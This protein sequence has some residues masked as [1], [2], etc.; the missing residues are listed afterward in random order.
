MADH[1]DSSSY[2]QQQEGANTP[3]AAVPASP[4]GQQSVVL[5]R[6]GHGDSMGE[7]GRAGAEFDEDPLVVAAWP[8][9][10]LLRV[11]YDQNRCVLWLLTYQS[12]LVYRSISRQ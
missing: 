9:G 11:L 12:S 8:G 2:Q 6:G 7:R 3:T 5:P 1:R 4:L 10:Q